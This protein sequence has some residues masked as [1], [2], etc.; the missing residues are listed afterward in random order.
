MQGHSVKFGFSTPTNFL[1]STRPKPVG[2]EACPDAATLC[3]NGCSDLDVDQGQFESRFTQP[4]IPASLRLFGGT[5]ARLNAEAGERLYVV[6]THLVLAGSREADGRTI[7]K[8]HKEGCCPSNNLTVRAART[9]GSGTFSGG[10]QGHSG[11]ARC[12]D[13]VLSSHPEPEHRRANGGYGPCSLTSH[14]AG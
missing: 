5:R 9:A 12:M 6:H 8:G 7:D 14:R 13:H 10:R 3:H 1:G 4:R 11:K 2:K